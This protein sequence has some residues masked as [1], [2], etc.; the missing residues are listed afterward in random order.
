VKV[1]EELESL[2]GAYVD[3]KID[4]PGLER[5]NALLRRDAESRRVFAELLNVDSALA[6]LAADWTAVRQPPRRGWA[7]HPVITAAAACVALAFGGWWWAR[8]T[9]PFATVME[10]AGCPGWVEDAEL[11]GERCEIKAGTMSLR[12]ARGARL[13]IEAPAEFSFESAQRIRVRRGRLAAEV[14]PTAKGFTVITPT[15]DAIDLGTRFGVDVPLARAAEVHVFEGEVIAKAAGA[16]EKQ[17]LRGGDAVSF[18]EHVHTVR[19]LR[20][21]AF[22]QPDEMPGL[23]AGL[24]AG[25][26]ARSEAALAVL[27]RDPDLIALF[28]FEAPEPLPGV[29][30]RVQGRWP[31]SHAPEFVG[32]GDHL[33]LDVGGL[34]SWPRLTLAAWVRLDRLGAPY[35][36]LLHTDGW[37]KDRP[38]QVHWM[39]TELTTMRL[40]LYA[41]QLAPGAEETHGYPDSRT[42]VLPEQGRWV[43]LVVV[44]DCEAGTVRFFF[45]GRF[46]KETL[47]SVANPARLGPAQIGN[48]DRHDR[49]LSG[50][51]DELILLGR[52]MSDE[53]VRALFEAG[54]PYR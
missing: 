16:T 17:S 34:R 53:E 26:R 30:R 20:T 19:E 35:Q 43:H 25:Q 41:N 4:E 18:G 49:K 21:S 5:L 32:V 9:A 31:G 54:T 45:N 44:Y 15:G 3:G 22:I 2:I 28:D 11:R 12:T 33:K 50:R 47:Q 42:S 14:P 48:W 29:Y 24:A 27:R 23:S 36:S 51:V 1:K 7:F 6:A 38:G 39:I 40:A 46:D 13:V 37:G 8:S 10:A 52:A